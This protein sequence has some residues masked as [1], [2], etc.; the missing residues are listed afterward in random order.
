M[1]PTRP[2]IPTQT[3]AMLL[4]ALV[5]LGA[6]LGVRHF[7]PVGVPAAAVV[8]AALRADL[9]TLPAGIEHQLAEWH[10]AHPTEPSGASALGRSATVLGLPWGNIPGPDGRSSIYSAAEP[11]ALR[12]TDIVGAVERLESQPGLTV[13][14]IRIETGG[15]RT[16]RQFS[17]VEITV[18]V[19]PEERPL[20]PVRRAEEPHAG[21]G[22]GRE[23]AGLRETGSGPLAAVRPPPPPAI[24][25]AGSV[26]RPGAASGPATLAP[27]S[28]R[29]IPE[30]KPKTH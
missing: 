15:S 20:N 30:P 5:W 18:Q 19:L 6:V 21:P 25:A 27:A 10:Q 23:S 9:A 8:V 29:F 17:A 2:P 26:S 13:Q 7:R 12:W 14:G 16:L 4:L 28:E 22:S 24:P 1:N 11:T 3:W